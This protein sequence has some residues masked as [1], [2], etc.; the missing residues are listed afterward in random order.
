MEIPAKACM[1]VKRKKDYAPLT[2][3]PSQLEC[4]KCGAKLMHVIAG[5]VGQIY[6]CNKCGYRGS[7][8]LEPGKIKL[9]RKTKI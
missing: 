9:D 1:P 2:N 8:G 5:A 7:V 3:M 6:V 4:P